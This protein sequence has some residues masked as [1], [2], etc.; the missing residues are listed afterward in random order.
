MND[1]KTKILDTAEDLIQHVGVNAMSYKHIAE[2]VGIRKASI[3][4][5]FAQKEK[6]VNELLERC[7]KT[8]GDQYKD[9]VEGEGRAPVKLRQLAEVYEQ[10][11]IKGRICLVGSMSSDRNTLHTDS[12]KVLDYTIQKTIRTFR[13]V[14]AQGKEEESLVFT[15]SPDEAASAYFSFLVGAQIIALSLN[16]VE[17]FRK[18]VKVIID[19]YV[20]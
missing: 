4:H 11:L 19:A 6:L 18:S 15:E 10:G 2:A 1:T 12:C 3:H 5:H 7:Q 16:G 13:E 14:F 8:Y 20:R 17:G 9:I